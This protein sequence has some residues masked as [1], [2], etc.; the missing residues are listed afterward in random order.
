MSFAKLK[1]KALLHGLTLTK[2][3]KYYR[4]ESY[5]CYKHELYL[6]YI[7]YEIDFYALNGR[8]SSQKCVRH[9]ITFE[10]V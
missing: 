8:F 5:Q 10:I 7:K 4:L 6:K 9:P 1:N 3:G 2:K